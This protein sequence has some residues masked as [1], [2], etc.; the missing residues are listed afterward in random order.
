[1]GNDGIFLFLGEL[2]L[3]VLWHF[4]P[5]QVTLTHLLKNIKKK[6]WL[7]QDSLLHIVRCRGV[8]TSRGC[9]VRD[10]V[11]ALLE[12]TVQYIFLCGSTWCNLLS[13]HLSECYFIFCRQWVLLRSLLCHPRP[14][15]SQ[16]SHIRLQLI[17]LDL[18]AQP[19]LLH[20]MC[21]YVHVCGRDILG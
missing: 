13:F 7:S 15:W 1:M 18:A 8:K 9:T 11:P 14:K 5:Y 12:C 2:C 16:A 21:I 4:F 20:T 10:N 3:P 19:S 17:H 6:T